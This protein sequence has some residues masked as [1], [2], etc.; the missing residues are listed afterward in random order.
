[1]AD[2]GQDQYFWAEMVETLG[3]GNHVKTFDG[4]TLA[5]AIRRAIDGPE[6]STRARSLAS[7]QSCLWRVRQPLMGTGI[8]KEDGVGCAIEHI[9][10]HLAVAR[11][12]SD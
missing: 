12:G 10:R 8:E 11:R 2:Q 4:P 6:Q 1:M 7:S 9:Y 5:R 3:V